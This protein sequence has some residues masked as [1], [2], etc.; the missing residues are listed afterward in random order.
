MYKAKFALPEYSAD[1]IDNLSRIWLIFGGNQILVEIVNKSLV[2]RHT[3]F[4]LL[5]KGVNLFK[6]DFWQLF[7]RIWILFVQHSK[8]FTM[9]E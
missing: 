5:E 7:G 1:R 8:R 4:W 9:S 2:G 6:T 3:T